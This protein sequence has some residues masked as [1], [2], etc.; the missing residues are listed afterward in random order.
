MRQI[1]RK[2]YKNDIIDYIDI[3]ND[4][5]YR[6]NK[7]CGKSYIL[8]RIENT[9]YRYEFIIMN[10]DFETVF[11]YNIEIRGM[12]IKTTCEEVELV[13]LYTKSFEESL[14][15]DYDISMKN[16]ERLISC[17]NW[18]Y[19]KSFKYINEYVQH[20]ENINNIND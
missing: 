10:I 8:D 3:I 1:D 6:D 20:L 17:G 12:E 5:K 14:K 2:E 16:L 7:H 18:E 13:D 4:P 19:Q 15:F 11:L 9:K